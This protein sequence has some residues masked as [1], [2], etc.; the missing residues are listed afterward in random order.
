M[1][2]KKFVKSRPK[3]RR[4]AR[5]VMTAKAVKA[6]VNK[7]M[8]RNLE[9]KSYDVINYGNDLGQIQGTASGY[10]TYD[11][12][13]QPAQGTTG[14][15]RVG[16]SINLTSLHTALQIYE[17]GDA[18]SGRVKFR[19]MYVLDTAPCSTDVYTTGD[20]NNPIEKMYNVNGFIKTF[21]GAQATVKDISSNRNQE[22]Y[23]RFRIL[24]SGE[25]SM[26]PDTITNTSNRLVTAKMG[27]KFRKP[28]PL[29]LNSS[30]E[31]LHHRVI[32][33]IFASSGNVGL[34]SN[35]LG[36]VP[37]LAADSGYIFNHESVSYFTDA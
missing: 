25:T 17:Q 13:P 20:S 15:Q 30:N 3:K 23:S 31:A 10:L 12:T 34:A 7:S 14:K 16:D 4:P 5:S 6:I 37:D 11:I 19:Y 27:Y 28:L 2:T 18:S 36:G 1:P 35:L 29:K 8:N 32:L 26:R 33:L 24:R 9:K 21:S 22:F